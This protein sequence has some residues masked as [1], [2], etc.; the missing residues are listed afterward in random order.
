MVR[1]FRRGVVD[2]CPVV[3]E[4]DLSQVHGIFRR[5]CGE[6]RGTILRSIGGK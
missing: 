3:V 4:Q 6:L 1:A 2:D 5:L